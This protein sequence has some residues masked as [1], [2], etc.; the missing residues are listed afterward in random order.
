MKL[1]IILVRDQQR[2]Q[3]MLTQKL[4]FTKPKKA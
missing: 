2:T 4:Y 1:V 3:K